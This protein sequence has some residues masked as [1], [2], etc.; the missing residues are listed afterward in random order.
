MKKILF[1]IFSFL[2]FSNADY[3]VTNSVNSNI[4]CASSFSKNTRDNNIFI[5]IT[6]Y[7]TGTNDVQ[8]F[9][10]TRSI[11]TV[12]S[13]YILNESNV[14]IR[15]ESKQSF[16]LT[17]IFKILFINSD[18]DLLKKY[19][20]AL[21]T[22]D[23]KEFSIKPVFK[24]TFTDN[25]TYCTKGYGRYYGQEKYIYNPN[26]PMDPS[27]MRAD[28]KIVKS[29]QFNY[30]Y[31]YLTKECFLSSGDTAYDLPNDLGTPTENFSSN[32]PTQTEKFKA[33]YSLF[34]SA[35][36]LPNPN[37]QINDIIIDT[38]SSSLNCNN[39]FYTLQEKMLCEMN[40]GIRKLNQ[41]ANPKYSLNNLI[42][43]LI[44]SNNKNAQDT[45]ESI[46]SISAF[47]EVRLQKQKDTNTLLDTTVTKQN[48]LNTTLSNIETTL[49]GIETNTTG[50]I[51][52]GGGSTG[53][54]VTPEPQ[55]IDL[56]KYF[57]ADETV[58]IDDI[59]TINDDTDSIISSLFSSFTDFKTN[60]TDSVDSINNQ[61]DGLKETIENPTNI[62]S[63]ST[64]VNCPVSYQ[65]D[66]SA[67]G[68]GKK[69]LTIDYCEFT[70]RLQPI[71]Y[72]FTYVTLLIGLIFFSFRFIGVLI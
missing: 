50:G 53:G 23:F 20:N 37:P 8:T 64:I 42:S 69:T 57:K 26:Y 55:E 47:E 46:K 45:N 17:S 4:V 6:G 28:T 56:D 40:A 61:L 68:I 3:L 70:S 32:T 12:K 43:I 51:V 39:S 27:Y 58:N 36:N 14:C 16:D 62:F 5:D 33:Y 10:F 44:T 67:F 9:Q 25:S 72:F 49:K 52:S 24:Y 38:T 18:N 48:E 34:E 31:N 60:I 41:E 2:S 30:T 15:D 21:E 59:N 1:L 7:S 65:A 63:K 13:G 35:N 54:T 66:F 22:N 71:V 29:I 19:E 11:L